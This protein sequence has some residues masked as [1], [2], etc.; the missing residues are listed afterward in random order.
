M[1]DYYDLFVKLS[2]QQCCKD[3]YLDKQKVWMHNNASV[4]LQSLQAEMKKNDCVDVLVRLLNYDDD[5]V[6]LNAASLCIHM[7]VL[8]DEAKS[9]LK[10]IVDC[11]TDSV[12]SFSA[13]MV[14]RSIT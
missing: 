4:K 7:G 12:M 13:K 1:K 3:D 10:N 9:A 5:R 6:R 11:S 2:L 14:L 8:C